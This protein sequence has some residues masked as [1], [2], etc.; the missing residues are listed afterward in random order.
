MELIINIGDQFMKPAKI[1]KDICTV[2]DIHTVTNFKGKIVNIIPIAKYRF[3]GKDVF[4]ETTQTTVK[5][6]KV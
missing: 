1:R 3:L 4:Y 6:Y 5:R 2:V